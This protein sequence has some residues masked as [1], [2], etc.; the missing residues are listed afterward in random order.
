MLHEQ[1]V[2][3]RHRKWCA[4][5]TVRSEHARRFRDDEPQASKQSAF[6]RFLWPHGYSYR[7]DR[8]NTD[9]FIQTPRQLRELMV[10][11]GWSTGSMETCPILTSHKLK[12]WRAYLE[13]WHIVQ[14]IKYENDT[15]FFN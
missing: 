3:D 11:V 10:G 9:A 2:T 4:P 15:E 8:A 14:L 1:H 6:S 12:N 5:Q 13:S 7:V